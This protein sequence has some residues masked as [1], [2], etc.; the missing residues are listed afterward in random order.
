MNDLPMTSLGRVLTA[1]SH[2]E[3]DRVPFLLPVSIGCARDLGMS[4]KEYFSDPEQVVEGQL[5]ARAKYGHDF[6]SAFYYGPIEIEAFGGEV[7]FFADGPPNSG[8]PFIRSPED[9]ERFRPPDVEE[10]PCLTRVLRTAARLKAVAADEV[11]IVG[12]VM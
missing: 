2:K 8:R 1:L 4:I 7:L 10:S 6:L 3:P 12:V 9:I 11:P 5:R